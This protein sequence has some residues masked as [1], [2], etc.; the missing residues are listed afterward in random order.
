MFNHLYV[1]LYTYMHVYQQCKQNNLCGD[2]G[3]RCVAF[4]C[5]AEQSGVALHQMPRE[6]VADAAG[7]SSAPA[8]RHP[9]Y[10]YIPC[11]DFINLTELLGRD[12]LV[13]DVGAWLHHHEMVGRLRDERRE[14]FRQRVLTTL[15]QFPRIRS[16]Q[17]NHVV[18]G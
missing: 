10:F 2:D 9:L 15:L 7:F 16:Q 1:L 3:I 14:R 4:G 18:V 17:F 6:K 5:T 8:T 12:V 11:R 13:R